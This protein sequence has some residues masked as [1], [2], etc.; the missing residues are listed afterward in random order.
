MDG[1]APLSAPRV[2]AVTLSRDTS[3]TSTSSTDKPSTDTLSTGIFSTG[4]LSTGTLSTDTVSTGNTSKFTLSTDTLFTG[5]LSTETFPTTV[6]FNFFGL[7]RELRDKIYNQIYEAVEGSHG[8]SE[9]RITIPDVRLRFLSRTFKREYDEECSRND[10]TKQL[11]VKGV[12]MV[13][14]EED[15]DEEYYARRKGLPGLARHTTN[16][17]AVVPGCGCKCEGLTQS[18]CGA[19]FFEFDQDYITELALD[20]HDMFHWVQIYLTVPREKCLDKILRYLNSKEMHYGLGAHLAR[21]DPKTYK[22]MVLYPGCK[23]VDG[24]FNKFL[25]TWTAEGGL[26]IHDQAIEQSFEWTSR[27]QM[28]IDHEAA[29]KELQE[30]ARRYGF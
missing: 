7:P 21:S 18:F 20:Y 26:E 4:T 10:R 5:K 12:R 24:G 29:E 17:I 2:A 30:T 23:F 11:R 14:A 25:A 22:V 27:E 8:E 9:Y 13:D 28:Q 16:M 1:P 3:T 19:K 15:E 6:K